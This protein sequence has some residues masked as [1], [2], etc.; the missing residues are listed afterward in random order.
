MGPG[1]LAPDIF[2]E[3]L[4]M[5]VLGQPILPLCL[6]H[7]PTSLVGCGFFSSIVVRH[8]FT[9][10]FDVPGDILVVMLM[11]LCEDQ[12]MSAYSA[13]LTGTLCALKKKKI[14]FIYF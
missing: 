2:P 11:R 12:A 8:P 3:F 13:I 4:F 1:L 14:L 7:P 9:S 5:W 10:I 6:S